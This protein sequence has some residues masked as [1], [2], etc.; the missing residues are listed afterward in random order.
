MWIGIGPRLSSAHLSWTRWRCP[1]AVRVTLVLALLLLVSYTWAADPDAL[2]NIVHGQCVPDQQEHD[3]PKPC[4]M[5]AL[6]D[7][8]ERGYAV[9]KDLR[10]AAQFLLIPTARISGIERPKLLASDAPNYF[11]AAWQA[12][13][14]VEARAHRTLRA[15][16]SAWPSTQCS[17]A[18]RTS[19][20]FTSTASARMCATLCGNTK[21]R[22]VSNGLRPTLRSQAI[23]TWQCGYWGSSSVRQIRSSCWRVGFSARRKIWGGIRWS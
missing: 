14:Y 1:A 6:Q 23:A 16:A 17:P 5:V 4:A 18:H 19:C 2:W 21:L 10:G 8:L 3:N 9:L 15:K 13:S 22:S 12:R 20:T 11:A 7:G